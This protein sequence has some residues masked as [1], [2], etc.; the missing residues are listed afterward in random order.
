MTRLGGIATLPAYSSVKSGG[1]FISIRILL[2]VDPTVDKN[3]FISRMCIS[4]VGAA[5]CFMP[6]FV[7]TLGQA[8]VNQN[9]TSFQGQI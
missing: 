6:E 1:R 4:Y 7:E 3:R 9:K 5:F 2:A 8:S